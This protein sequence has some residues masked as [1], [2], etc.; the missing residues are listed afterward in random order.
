M[1][2]LNNFSPFLPQLTKGCV[3][4]HLVGSESGY[5]SLA[6]K[7]CK[8][9]LSSNNTFSICATID[10]KPARI[11]WVKSTRAR[12]AAKSILTQ[13]RFDR[14]DSPLNTT[15][16]FKAEQSSKTTIFFDT[17]CAATVGNQLFVARRSR[18][19]LL[20]V[21]KRD[22]MSPGFLASRLG[23][24]AVGSAGLD[25]ELQ[26]EAC[27]SGGGT[28][29]QVAATVEAVRLSWSAARSMAAAA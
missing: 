14:T 23:Q 18:I 6:S 17:Q 13:G 7:E 3:G 26:S 15:I 29:Q 20:E 19:A 16:D 24:V 9:S 1:L 11:D 21:R 28:M 25:C 10:F 27:D 5:S 4:D 8:N 12:T 22:S 2:P